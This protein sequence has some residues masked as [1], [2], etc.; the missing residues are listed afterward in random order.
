MFTRAGL[1]SVAV[2]LMLGIGMSGLA[3]A[4]DPAPPAGM[5][6][7]KLE[8]PKLAYTGTGRPINTKN[9]EPKDTKRE[10]IFVPEGIENL[11]LNKPVTSSEKSP[12]IGELTYVTDGDKQA[13]EG[14]YVE[15]G[16]GVQWVQIDLGAVCSLYAVAVWHYHMEARVY[17]DTIIQISDDP[18]FLTNVQTVFNNDNDNSAGLGI[19]S[20][21]EYIESN[22]GRPIDLKGA[23]ARYIRLYGKGNSA[24]DA[25]HYT[26]VEVWGTPGA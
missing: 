13:A 19:G 14:S 5:K 11:S 20:D 9:L 7:L 15:L 10:P 2:V 4:Q 24:N 21:K 16:G 23:K 1:V 12:I 6:N 22:L 18:D 3:F 8:L 26:E 17:R 25:N